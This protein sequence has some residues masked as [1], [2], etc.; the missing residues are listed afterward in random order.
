MKY[1]RRSNNNQFMEIYNSETLPWQK[2]YKEALLRNKVTTVVGG[3]MDE[4]RFLPSNFLTKLQLTMSGG[5]I[6]LKKIQIKIV[7]L[8][9]RNAGVS[10]KLYLRD[11]TDTTGRKL[12]CTKRLNLGTEIRLSLP[13][14]DY[15]VS[16][17]SDVPIVFGFEELQ[18]P[19]LE[20]RELFHVSLTWLFG[21]STMSY[22]MPATRMSVTTLEEHPQKRTNR[23]I[24]KIEQAT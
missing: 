19:F 14:L 16:T 24:P 22:S 2:H 20:G 5:F 9:S 4:V 17:R 21:L 6:T 23:D 12:H 1:L 8:V 11:I 10:G 7:P 15:L 3:E 18:S 13:H